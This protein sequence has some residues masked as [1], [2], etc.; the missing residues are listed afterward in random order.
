MTVWLCVCNR[1]RPP[2]VSSTTTS[3]VCSL[4]ISSVAYELVHVL[5]SQLF[6]I[7]TMA[8]TAQT[9][10]FLTMQAAIVT[11]VTSADKWPRLCEDRRTLFGGENLLEGEFYHETI[12]KEA[13]RA[14]GFLDESS[15]EIAWHTDY[16]D[17]YIYNPKFWVETFPD[18]RRFIAAMSIRDSLKKLH[19]DDLFDSV[20]IMTARY[21]YLRGCLVGLHWAAE[22]YAD[23]SL[24][25]SVD[26]VGAAHNVLGV[27]LHALQD[28]Y[29][30]SN[31]IDES[32]RR[33]KIFCE[34]LPAE[35]I[36]NTHLYTGYY[37]KEK[38]AKAHGKPL[39]IC[40]LS[41]IDSCIDSVL[42]F[43]CSG[44][45]TGASASDICKEYD[46]C[47]D[48]RSADG[49]G[50]WVD[51]KDFPV[52]YK[53]GI[54]LDNKWQAKFGVQVRGISN[55]LKGED[56][57]EI[58]KELATEESKE[59]LK[60]AGKIVRD[61]GYS[62]FWD[63]V[64]KRRPLKPRENQFEKFDHFPFQFITAGG[65]FQRNSTEGYYLRVTL[66]TSHESGAGTDADISLIACW[67]DCNKRDDYEKKEKI[68]LDYT[69]GA[70]IAGHDD[71]EEGSVAVYTV[72]PFE[73]LPTAIYFR[74]DDA[75]AVEV[76]HAFI[77]LIARAYEALA[78][79][80]IELLGIGADFVGADTEVFEPSVL[81]II[82]ESKC[83]YNDDKNT[84]KQNCQEFSMR[85]DGNREGVYEVDF[86]VSLEKQTDTSA[87]Y[88]IEARMLNCIKESTIDGDFDDEPFV[89]I[90][91]TYNGG[92]ES[93]RPNN[94]K[95]P[96]S[97]TDTGEGRWLGYS[98]SIE[99][100]KSI[101][102]FI[103]SI[104]VWESDL[105]SKYDRMSI[106]NEF[107]GKDDDVKEAED[108]F[109]GTL[110][111]FIDPDWKLKSVNVYGFSRGKTLEAGQ[112]LTNNDARWV[113]GGEE[114]DLFQL[115]RNGMKQFR[116]VDMFS[117]P[118]Q[119]SKKRRRRRR[120]YPNPATVKTEVAGAEMPILRDPSELSPERLRRRR[121]PSR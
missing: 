74:N 111:K 33:N 20:D 68:L 119:P 11:L 88:T 93:M 26:P 56:A 48:A 32:T 35:N 59:W 1:L 29:S 40:T 16:T 95:R 45:L 97:D 104:E 23:P 78:E 66:A 79:F 120:R 80:I 99:I 43:Y 84:V 22:V 92:E 21:R 7:D 3:V 81:P 72:G 38:T 2:A 65:D 34:M 54:N 114:T 46:G 107:I 77:K 28:F 41:Q 13:S 47:D 51:L 115:D 108:S 75:S 10:L 109:F 83:K 31:W 98:T 4:F 82:E 116:G 25:P 102:A 39:I 63:H 105:E 5:V 53:P 113:K 55:D 27:T 42:S 90:L 49:G 64:Q 73:T 57:F 52:Y 87:S 18:N 117:D 50:I 19:F 14:V 110:G 8:I 60:T 69:P 6:H 12:S 89:M 76:V 70:Q 118:C 58:A 67:D 36:W 91:I 30:H 44:L 17:S 112:V 121:Q 106:Y 24:A 101:G 62:D 61:W 9:L 100:P 96:F 85:V 15:A 86:W 37:E 71:F 94:G 103:I